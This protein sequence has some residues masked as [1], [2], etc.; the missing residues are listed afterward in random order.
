MNTRSRLQY[1]MRSDGTIG[2]EGAPDIKLT[3]VDIEP[4]ADWMN[5]LGLPHL[6]DERSE[7]DNLAKLRS[8]KRRGR[9]SF[10]VLDQSETRLTGK[11]RYDPKHIGLPSTCGLEMGHSTY[12]VGMVDSF[13]MGLDEGRDVLPFGFTPPA[14]VEG[15]FIGGT[16]HFFDSPLADVAMTAVQRGVFASTCGVVL[17][18]PDG[19][20]ALL[21]VSLIPSA[22]AGNQNARI[23]SFSA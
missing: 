22:L 2:L 12:L 16:A 4:S 18:V 1:D 21:E 23:L 8:P 9:V 15:N 13:V 3:L 17:S 19:S 5:Q 10:I 11:I 6:I 20:G 7:W 14:G